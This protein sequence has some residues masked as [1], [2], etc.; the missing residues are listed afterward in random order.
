MKMVATSWHSIQSTAHQS[1][2][3]TSPLDLSTVSGKLKS[4][5]ARPEDPSLVPLWPFMELEPLYASSTLKTTKWRNWLWW[6]LEAKR[7]GSCQTHTS[8]W[9]LKP[10]CSVSRVRECTT[11]LHCGRFTNNIFALDSVSGTPDVP[12]WIS[13][14]CLTRNRVF[15]SCS[16]PSCILPDYRFFT[17][18]A[19]SLS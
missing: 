6:K 17:K 16:T 8:P 13:I 10:S 9:L 14:N 5:R 19:L 12:H 15:T 4:S 7:S 3:A 1:S 18:C 2:T 11:T